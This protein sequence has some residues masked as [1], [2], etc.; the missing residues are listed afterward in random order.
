MNTSKLKKGMIISNYREFCK[1][2]EEKPVT[3]SKAKEKQFVDWAH[4]FDFG[5]INGTNKF[6]IFKVYKKPIEQLKEAGNRSVYVTYI[7]TILLQHLKGL[8]GY[9]TVLSKIEAFR[10]LGM[11]N[12]NYGNSSEERKLVESVSS[13]LDDGYLYLNHIKSTAYTRF[14]SILTSALESLV[15]RK[16]ITCDKQYRIVTK[17]GRD[18]AANEVEVSQILRVEY[19]VLLDMGYKKIQ[20]VFLSGKRNEFYN[21]VGTILYQKYGYDRYYTALNIIYAHENVIE[22][23]E[24]N[25]LELTKIDLN[26]LT[27]NAVTKT[28]NTK[29]KN[30]ENKIK[31][32]Q[33]NI[34]VGLLKKESTKEHMTNSKFYPSNYEEINKVLAQGLLSYIL[35]QK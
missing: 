32:E 30:H 8:Q 11:I 22:S 16:I 9:S 1:L 5:N 19:Q 10:L 28:M 2:I 25:K 23:L 4:Y 14:N 3:N 33:D 34:K 18:L 12:S 7:E 17:D 24:Q 31:K 21:D 29:K 26:Q 13:N 27:T 15:D 6:E 35:E 20:Q